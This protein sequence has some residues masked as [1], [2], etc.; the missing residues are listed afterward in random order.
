[1]QT[2]KA[3]IEGRNTSTDA[4]GFF[5]GPYVEFMR[6]D[7]V[8]AN[9]PPLPPYRPLSKGRTSIS[10]V[11]NKDGYNNDDSGYIGSPGMNVLNVTLSEK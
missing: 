10:K 5:P 11:N 2:P 4:V 9:P 7:K 6:M 1:M 3:W 8:I